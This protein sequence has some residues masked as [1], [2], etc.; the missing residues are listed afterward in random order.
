MRAIGVWIVQM[1]SNA[2]KGD[3]VG[4]FRKKA[5]A[6]DF[7]VGMGYQITPSSGVWAD[8]QEHKFTTV[9]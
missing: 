2:T 5:G 3:I 1:R 8:I 9:L 4:V 6:L 7:C